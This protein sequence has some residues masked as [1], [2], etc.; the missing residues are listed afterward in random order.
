ML[1]TEKYFLI[2]LASISKNLLCGLTFLSFKDYLFIWLDLSCSTQGLLVST[3]KLL[4]HAH[5]LV[6]ACGSKFPDQRLDPMPPVLGAWSLSPWTIQG[7]PSLTFLIGN[8][9]NPPFGLQGR[10]RKANNA[11]FQQIG[12]G[13]TFVPRRTKKYLYPG[14]RHRVLFGFKTI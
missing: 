7:S 14:G 12:N 4:Q 6:M 9:L 10:S 8:C 3:G 1:E 2:F 13:D 11:Y 5:S